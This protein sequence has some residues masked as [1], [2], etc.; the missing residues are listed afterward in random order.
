M[1]D[2]VAVCPDFV[3]IDN[4]KRQANV[5]AYEFFKQI[6]DHIDSAETQKA[7]IKPKES[8]KDPVDRFASHVLL[9]NVAFGA[10]ANIFFSIRDSI[11]VLADPLEHHFSTVQARLND[12]ICSLDEVISGR[13]TMETLDAFE[14]DILECY[15]LPASGTYFQSAYAWMTG[16]KTS[17]HDWYRQIAL[18]EIPCLIQQLRQRMQ[19]SMNLAALRSGSCLT[20]FPPIRSQ[21]HGS[22]PRRSVQI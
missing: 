22:L 2:Y 8:V 5:L 15:T 4:I 21:Q 11:V 16:P 3:L 13:W 9:I 17:S 14:R 1:L 7:H 19:G 20:A 18:K 6:Y 10:V 12:P